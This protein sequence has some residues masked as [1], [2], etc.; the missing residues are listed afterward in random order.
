MSILSIPLGPRE[1]LINLAT[2]L[3]ANMF[4]YLNYISKYA[5]ILMEEPSSR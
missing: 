5:V 3:A 1:V 4:A 2:V